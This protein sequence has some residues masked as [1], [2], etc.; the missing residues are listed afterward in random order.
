ML[1]Q[2]SL[3]WLMACERLKD[4]MTI[5]EQQCEVI[6]HRFDQLDR[7]PTMAERD[8]R[9]QAYIENRARL[10]DLTSEIAAINH[11]LQAHQ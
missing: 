5:V 7:E 1:D 4:E 10:A 11:R 2:Q 3:Q 6:L 8:A 9:R